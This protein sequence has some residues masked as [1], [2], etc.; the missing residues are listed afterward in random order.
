MLKARLGTASCHAT[1]AEAVSPHASVGAV[2]VV[3]VC[4][5]LSSVE[6]DVGEY[7]ESVVGG[8]GGGREKG[9]EGEGEALG[10]EGEGA[11]VLVPG[12]VYRIRELGGES[13]EGSSKSQGTPCLV[14]FP[15]MGWA[16]SH[17]GGGLAVY[18]HVGGEFGR[19]GRGGG[20]GT[21]GR[22]DL[23]ISNWGRGI[24][25]EL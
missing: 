11:V 2:K 8:R 13:A 16:S 5:S 18:S 20:L 4:S 21:D 17:W 1:P 12:V 23:G 3:Y 24:G 19:G 25:G 9:I 10:S 7:G 14:Q 6:R 15:Q 22:R